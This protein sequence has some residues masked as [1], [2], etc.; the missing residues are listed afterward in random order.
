MT[1]LLTVAQTKTLIGLVIDVAQA[2]IVLA[3]ALRDTD[4]ATKRLGRLLLGETGVVDADD[5]ST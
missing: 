4:Q 5:T 3:N 2:D 1:E